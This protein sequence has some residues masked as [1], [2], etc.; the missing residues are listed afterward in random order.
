MC[1]STW[2]VLGISRQIVT[3]GTLLTIVIVI[4]DCFGL[5]I[6]YVGF[7]PSMLECSL[8]MNPVSL[9]A[10]LIV[11]YAYFAAEVNT[12]QIPSFLQK[13]DLF[14]WNSVIVWSGI[15]S[16]KKTPIWS[17]SVAMSMPNGISTRLYF[18][19][20][21]RHCISICVYWCMIMQGYKW[22][23][24]HTIHLQAER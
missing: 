8:V 19:L 22:V 9:S 23:S 7:E 21:F 2:T 6:I 24:L 12:L 14:G 20:L 11:G 10:L 5:E 16:G 18:Q 4:F 13:Q 15:T 17:K 1:T 3:L